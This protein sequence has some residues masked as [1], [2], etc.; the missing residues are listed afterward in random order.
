V[1][2]WCVHLG[3]AAPDPG[4]RAV[5]AL[6]VGYLALRFGTVSPEASELVRT[7]AAD[8]AFRTAHPAIEDAVRLLERLAA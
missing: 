1:E 5:A 3:R 4:M 6:G 7:L 8:K 2:G